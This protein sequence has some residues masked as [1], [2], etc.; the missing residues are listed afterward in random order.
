MRLI[1]CTLQVQTEKEGEQ[2]ILGL[3]MIPTSGK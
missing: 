1:N 2:T 3:K